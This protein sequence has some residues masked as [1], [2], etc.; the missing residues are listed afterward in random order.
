MPFFA[1]Q[2]LRAGNLGQDS[3]FATYTGSTTQTIGSGADTVV[4]FGTADVT[5]SLI[6]RSTQG[7]G[8]KFTMG[9][10][11]LVAVSVTVRWSTTGASSTGEK[12]MH[13]E[14]AAGIWHHSSDIP[15]NSAVPITNHVSFVK[16]LDAGDAV[17]VEVFQNSGGDEDLDANAFLAVPR[18]DIGFIL[19]ET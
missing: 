4:A 6:T 9:A 11:G 16:P 8:H 7:A 3:A 17:V 15:A 14:N 5:S 10:S 19:V 12:N 2:K 1:G 13:V 18:I